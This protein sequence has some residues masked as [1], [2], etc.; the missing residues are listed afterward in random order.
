MRRKSAAILAKVPKLTSSS[1]KSVRCE[2]SSRRALS[3]RE[4]AWAPPRRDSVPGRRSPGDG[5]ALRFGFPMTAPAAFRL[6]L[7]S[8]VPGDHPLTALRILSVALFAFLLGAC[9]RGP[10]TWYGVPETELPSFNRLVLKT[11]F[12]YPRNGTHTYWWPKRTDEDFVSYDGCSADVFLQG[13]QVM[14]GETGGR[15][16]CCGWT[17]EVFAKSYE[18]WLEG[19]QSGPEPRLAPQ[20][21][22][23]FKRLWFVEDLNGPG[24]SAALEAFQ[25]GR[26][27]PWQEALPGDFMQ[28]W[29]TENEEEKITGHSVIFLQWIDGGRGFRY[30]S[31]Q[32]STNGIGANTEHFG[33]Y[34]NVTPTYTYF[35]RADPA[36][37]P[38]TE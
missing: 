7:P 13:E 9:A 21:F 14:R 33:T 11:A 4:P 20:D 6:A 24:P 34:G 16:F 15:T 10:K 18:R 2:D 8:F 37:E 19:R 3:T 28:I 29:R 32:E 25:V 5:C 1:V 38:A 12:E 23:E 26:E 31:T 27:I 17:L 36:I 22:G 35:G 30:I